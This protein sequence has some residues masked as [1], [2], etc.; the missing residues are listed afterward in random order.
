MS[1]ISNGESSDLSNEDLHR[2]L[3]FAGI[4]NHW[5]GLDGGDDLP[6]ATIIVGEA[7]NWM[8]RFQLKRQP[9]RQQQLYRR[10]TTET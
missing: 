10:T 8:R 1:D 6:N 9:V 7:N 5:S 4:W 2:P 3:A